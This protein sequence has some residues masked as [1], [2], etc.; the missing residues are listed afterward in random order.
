MIPTLDGPSRWT[1]EE[2]L[3][4]DTADAPQFSCPNCKRDHRR[5]VGNVVL[6]DDWG[7]EGDYTERFFYFRCVVCRFAWDSKD[8]ELAPDWNV[9]VN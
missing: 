8:A 9:R 5:Y 6:F 4:F 3:D 2:I 1:R 7:G